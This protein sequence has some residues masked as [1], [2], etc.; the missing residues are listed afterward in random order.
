LV[1]V[2][3]QVLPP[4]L[5]QDFTTDQVSIVVERGQIYGITPG[6]GIARQFLS[7]GEEILILESQ[8]VTG[9]VQ[10]TKRLLGFS[11]RMRRW[12]EL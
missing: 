10:T 3:C 1:F 8:G 9:Y 2:L 5:A 6:E 11:G 7:S 4:C 12:V